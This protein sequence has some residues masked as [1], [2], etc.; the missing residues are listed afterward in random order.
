M[1]PEGELIKET[2]D[3]DTYPALVYVN[4]GLVHHMAPWGEGPAWSAADVEDFVRS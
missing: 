4:G 2:F 1:D 3:I